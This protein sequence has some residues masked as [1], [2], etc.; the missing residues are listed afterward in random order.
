MSQSLSGSRELK[1][2]YWT[3][4]GRATLK[5]ILAMGVQSCQDFPAIGLGAHIAEVTFTQFLDIKRKQNLPLR[6][7]GCRIIRYKEGQPLP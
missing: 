6:S 1:I 3:D 4:G 7:I 5:S 2:Y